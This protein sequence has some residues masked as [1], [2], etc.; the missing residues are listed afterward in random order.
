M[1]DEVKNQRRA[2]LTRQEILE[3]GITLADSEG[4]AAVTMR[5]LGELLGVE[6]MSLYRHVKNKQDV[7]DGMA[8]LL[9]AGMQPAVAAS[10][11]SWQQVVFQFARAYRR[12]IVEHPAVFMA[13]AG[14]ALVL[15]ENQT[16]L[17]RIIDTLTA[18]GFSRGDAMDIYLAG[19]SYARG[20][21]LTDLAHAQTAT[22]LDGFDTDR[23]FER[24]LDVLA[25]GFEQVRMSRHP[26][27]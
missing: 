10:E 25:A 26:V 11:A 13:Q 4:L 24:G 20:F 16:A 19:T 22:P 1:E 12:L 21:A 2:P 18:A 8:S 7:L 27:E 6:A 3:A 23:A 17:H 15:D 9:V 14:R 5:R